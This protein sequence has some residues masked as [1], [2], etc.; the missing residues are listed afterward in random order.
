MAATFV[1]DDPDC[2]YVEVKWDDHHQ[3]QQI[4]QQTVRGQWL[5]A[6]PVW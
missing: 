5:L 2:D 4:L 6:D 1:A 3:H